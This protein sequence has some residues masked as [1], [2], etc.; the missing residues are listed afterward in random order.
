[1]INKKI[2]L[3]ALLAGLTA[4]E[5]MAG[6]LTSYNIGDVLVC[7][8]NG[9]TRNL[10]VDAGPVSTFTNAAPNQRIA[11]SQYTAVQFDAAFGDADDVNWSAFTWFDGNVSPASAQW[12]LFVTKQRTDPNIQSTPWPAGTAG[13]QQ[14]VASLMAEI[15]TGA[16]FKLGFNSHN[17]ASAIIEPQAAANYLP[18]QGTSYFNAINSSIGL[19]DFG[20]NFSGSPEIMTG[21]DFDSSGAVLRSDLYQIPP[22]TSSSTFIGYFE[23]A[24]DGTMSYV[25]YPTATPVIQSISRSNNVSTITCI[26]GTYGNYTLRGITT[27]NSGVSATNWPVVATVPNGT[28]SIQT[29]NDT[30]SSPAKFY[31]ITAQ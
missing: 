25:A 15:A 23:M 28:T 18:L 21:D 13:S 29:I 31:I 26:T 8:R 4:G 10:I 9:Q 22:G 7:F 12:T 1:M 6:S 11:I 3:M 27:L 30:D 17:S 20:G 19:T 2:G 5:I 24:D 16:S 14:G